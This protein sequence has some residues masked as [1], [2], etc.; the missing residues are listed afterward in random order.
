[1][2][3]GCIA[4]GQMLAYPFDWIFL[5]ILASFLCIG[6]DIKQIGSITKQRHKSNS[7]MFFN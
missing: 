7:N 4:N 6:I 5:Q 2:R 1:M 3:P